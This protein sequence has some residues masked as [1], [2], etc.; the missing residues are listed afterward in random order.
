MANYKYT[1]SLDGDT[2]ELQKQLKDVWK[3]IGNTNAS[4][5]L[6]IDGKDV[7][8]K[9][10]DIWGK[11]SQSLEKDTINLSDLVDFGDTI[12]K[13]DETDET[14]K[15][16]KGSM[17]LLLNVIKELGKEKLSDTFT[18]LIDKI[19]TLIDKLDFLV[20]KI[21]GVSS[22]SEKSEKQ[23]HKEAENFIDDEEKKRKAIE[24]TAKTESKNKTPVKTQPNKN[25]S[26][27]NLRRENEQIKENI[28]SYEALLKLKQSVKNVKGKK[29]IYSEKG[30]ETDWI[31]LYESKQTAVES[32]LDEQ[33]K[34]LDANLNL[35]LSE[36]DKALEKLEERATKLKSTLQPIQDIVNRISSNSSISG[37]G[38]TSDPYKSYAKEYQAID[39]RLGELNKKYEL[40]NEEIEEYITL[41]VKA[42]K[43]MD[44][45]MSHSGGVKASGAKNKTE[46]KTWIQKDFARDLGEDPEK[47]YDGLLG[48]ITDAL[49]EGHAS[50]YDGNGKKRS[51]KEAVGAFLGY[52]SGAGRTGEYGIDQDTKELN[53]IN[54]IL[55]YIKENITTIA[56]TDFSEQI[57]KTRESVEA[58]RE[59]GLLQILEE[60]EKRLQNLLD[61]QARLTAATTDKKEGSSER[62]P[63]K[64]APTIKN[65]VV[66]NTS[67]GDSVS[68]AS[69]ATVER[70]VKSESELNAEIEKRENIIR[71]LQQLQENL[72]VHEDFHGNDRYFADQLPTEEEIR[73][74]DERIKQ[75]T[76]TNNIFDVDKL[77]QDR[78]EWLSEVKYSLE[79]YDDLIK[80][81]DQKAL[82]EYTT[83]GLSHISGAESFFGYEDNSFSIAPK[84]TKEK[85][86]IENEINDLYLDLD[87]LK[88]TQQQAEVTS[89]AI[90]KTKEELRTQLLSISSETGSVNSTDISS[91]LGLD[92]DFVNKDFVKLAFGDYTPEQIIDYFLKF[93]EE[94]EDASTSTSKLQKDLKETENQANK[95]AE[96][97]STAME[98]VA[99]KTDKATENQERFNEA[100]GRA[101][102]SMADYLDQID[103][104]THTYDPSALKGRDI[105]SQG[106]LKETYWSK[107]K[108][109]EYHEKGMF[110]FV[111]RLKDGQLQNILVKYDEETQQWYENTESLSTAFEKVGNEIISLDDQIAKYEMNR[112]KQK[113]ANPTYD[114][115][116]DEKLIT[117]AKDRQ[118]ILLETLQT[119]SDEEKYAYEISEFEKKQLQNQERLNALKQKQSNE[120]QAKQDTKDQIKINSDE[121]KRQ[122]EITKTNR[123]LNRQ[124]IIAQET[125]RTYD[126]KKNPDLDKSI[127][128]VTDLKELE[129]K[130]QEILD[131]INKL[132]DKVR[133]SS[134]EKDFLK[135]E[136]LMSEYRQM[137]KDKLK[138][139]NPTKQELGQQD[140]KVSIAQ[141]IG[142]YDELIAKAKTYGD[143]AADT[144]TTLEKQKEIL[145]ATND[146]GEYTATA[147]Q[148]NDA[149]DTYKIEKA[150]LVPLEIN[151]K[152]AK[153]VVTD[154]TQALS[155]YEALQT[156]IAKGNA[157]ESDRKEAEKLLNT[158]HELQRSD[159]LP[160]QELNKSNEKLKQ[161]RENVEEINRKKLTEFSEKSAKKLSAAISKYDYG[162]STEAQKLLQKFK[163]GPIGR[164]DQTDSTIKEYSTLLD[165][166]IAKL[167]KSH[168]EQEKSLSEE[169]K[170]DN[171]LKKTQVTLD[172]LDVPD[173]LKSDFDDLKKDVDELNRKLQSQEDKDKN[174]GLDDYRAAVKKRVKKFNDKKSQQ[175]LRNT[176]I[177]DAET[178][179]SNASKDGDYGSLETKVKS[180]IDQ[181]KNG[182]VEVK[183]F[184]QEIASLFSDYRKE[185]NKSSSSAK[186]MEDTIAGFNDRISKLSFSSVLTGEV[187]AQKNKLAAL[188]QE[189]REGTK[190]LDQY[191]VEAQQIVDTLKDWSKLGRSD[192]GKT[193]I[194]TLAEA[195]TAIQEYINKVGTLK[196]AIKG[197]DVA[198]A[199]GIT[200]W[201]AQIVTASGE[202]QNLAFKWSDSAHTLITTS[203]TVKTELTGVAKA[204][205]ALKKKTSDLILYWTANFANPYQIIGG[206]RKVINVATELDTAMVE[207]IK[208]SDETDEA[209]NNFSNTIAASAK[210]IASTNKELTTSAASYLRLGYNIKQAAQLAENTAVFVNV[211]DG[212]D[213]DTA[214]EDM[215]TAMKAF[216]IQAEESMK[217]IDSYNSIGK[218]IA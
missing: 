64:T 178:K 59:S 92:K 98:E 14:I 172:N 109:G 39:S 187:E 90:L 19:D 3:Q 7:T 179:L 151:Q 86:K 209:Y 210:K 165:D 74:A 80:T 17:G 114:T 202:V 169:I 62:K 70:Q 5:G 129:S 142:Q 190:T 152:E 194:N 135:L 216:D 43:I 77:I 75:L 97:E 132:T 121:R 78:N 201:T 182:K 123:L 183:A 9:V 180:L 112:D 99:A 105:I 37:L 217:I 52:N 128:N 30:H 23:H 4:I 28:D 184:K 193:G 89:K 144:V 107:D 117:L 84:F 118:A 198:D 54:S 45:M 208:V 156:K 66:N 38:D 42:E 101:A 104:E 108:D 34:E 25:E 40:T 160:Y 11:I 205:D 163:N 157:L 130:K 212:I 126:Q 170:L 138:S 88:E 207:V 147:T 29:S 100:Q 106:G 49:Y 197:T 55:S 36:D 158:I 120:L 141:L 103:R 154:L 6:T 171:A 102:T 149:R 133:D 175:S 13:L 12:S 173:E 176:A 85:G 164:L 60:E 161:I 188:D 122:A 95:T 131:L 136:Q 186:T 139:N 167:A 166:V 18:P 67:S 63:V 218:L 82:D 41:Q 31:G 20:D 83:R 162:D 127:S 2:S 56:H 215:I 111:E 134:T 155:K 73:E 57:E 195:K 79:E 48:N 35:I 16:V 47:I 211:G 22:E 213:I 143:E 51:I 8:K 26:D 146:K 91:V 206:F 76:G 196:G 58:F 174:F 61:M 33:K 189:V 21:D 181:L 1:I 53:E 119:Y 124:K 69:T 24:E 153:K 44:R 140:L 191:K 94:T 148:F 116:A 46:L 177:T 15:T 125:E 214:T 10:N 50:L 71:E 159:V 137:A 199:S 113:A 96:A 87:K 203:S 81:N 72:T 204:W 185:V 192:V 145:S 27:S 168:K 115:S 65:T 110:S 200:T 68:S 32:D 93:Y 150:G